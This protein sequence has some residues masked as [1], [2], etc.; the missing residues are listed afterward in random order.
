MKGEGFR[1]RL[2]ATLCLRKE[3]VLGTWL[4]DL[5]LERGLFEDRVAA[6]L[7]EDQGRIAEVETGKRLPKLRSKFS[8]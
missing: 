3:R 7:D 2:L 8:E 6:A 4:T 5:R 1:P